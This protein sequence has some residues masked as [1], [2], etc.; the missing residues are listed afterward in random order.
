MGPH[1]EQ[2]GSLVDANRLRFDFAHFEPVT[3]TQLDQIERLVNQQ[4]RANLSVLC[5][6]TFLEQAQQAGALALFS[7]KYGDKVRV[8]SIGDFSKELCGGTHIKAT[9]EIGFCKIILETAIAAGI[10][11]IEAITGEA[12]FNY[13]TTMQ[14]QLTTASKLLK[15]DQTQ[16]LPKLQQLTEQLQAQDKELNNLKSK[17]T[18]NTANTIAQQATTIGTTKLLISQLTNTN[19]KEMRNMVD[20]LKQK[21]QSAVILLATVADNKIQLIA[22]VTSDTTTKITAAEIIKTA[23]QQLGGTGGGKAELAQGGGTNVTELEKVFSTIKQWIA[24]KLN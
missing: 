18:S 5:E 6:T 16:L 23:T 24:E 22:G 19:P 2:K 13:I 14:Q 17:T 20:Q 8:I 12:A 9:G 7:D 11:R 15:T 21:L 10:R 3:K 4:I 1:V